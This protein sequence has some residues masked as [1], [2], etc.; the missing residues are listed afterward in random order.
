MVA[1]II[2][3]KQIG[4][5]YGIMQSIQNLG[6]ALATL[7]CGAIAEQAGYLLLEVFFICCLF[8][9]LIATVVLYLI[10]DYYGVGLNLTAKARQR[11][12]AEERDR[13][14]ML[15]NH[16]EASSQSES[17]HAEINYDVLTQPRDA[18]ALRH[19]FYSFV[20]P[21]AEE[22][23]EMYKARTTSMSRRSLVS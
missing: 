2:P 8:I 10:D 15:A 17:V 20:A 5:A 22:P 4:T 14:E 18:N 3:T 21:D 7:I 9:A 11:I 6:L 1:L 12:E 13:A 16:S 23:V 19:R